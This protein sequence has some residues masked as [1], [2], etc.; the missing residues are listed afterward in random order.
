MPR[1]QVYQTLLD[2]GFLMQNNFE[3]TPLDLFPATAATAAAATAAA[4]A[5]AAAAAVEL[6]RPMLLFVDE[7]SHPELRNLAVALLQQ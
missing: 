1:L 4:A 3:K 6:A 5:A 7:C 2:V